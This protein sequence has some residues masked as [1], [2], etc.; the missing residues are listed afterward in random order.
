VRQPGVTLSNLIQPLTTADFIQNFWTTETPFLA[1]DAGDCLQMLSGIPEF[2][3]PETLA[4]ASPEDIAL[5]CRDG[6]RALCP[7]AEAMSCYHRGDTLYVIALEESIDVLKE[8]RRPLADDL[9]IPHNAVRFEAFAARAGGVS[10]WHYDW[11]VNFQVLLQGRKTWHLKRNSNVTNPDASLVPG[12]DWPAEAF[13]SDRVLPET[14]EEDVLTIEATPGTVLF[15]PRGMWHQTHSETDCLGVNFVLRPPMWHE[16]IT[17]SLRDRAHRHAAFRTFAFGTLHRNFLQSSAKAA[18][19]Q[20][21][22]ELIEELQQLRFDEL[23]LTAFPGVY[24]WPRGL[25]PK[26]TRQKTTETKSS[27]EFLSV[28]SSVPG[29]C[30][31]CNLPARVESLLRELCRLRHSFA[32]REAMW[33]APGLSREEVLQTIHQLVDA[34]LLEV[35]SH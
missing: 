20:R 29:S 7:P 23:G 25:P 18:F 32:L 8:I 22:Q 27:E 11:D 14:F 28:T 19:E 9:G 1:D 26:I 6:F 34:K 15:L 5:F 35:V 10:T 30:A 17:R 12:Q 13:A 4:N 2:Q 16:L 3:S 24:R 33:F 31:T 21:K